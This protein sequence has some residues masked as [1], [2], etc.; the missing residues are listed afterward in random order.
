MEAKKTPSEQEDLAPSELKMEGRVS[1][2]DMNKEAEDHQDDRVSQVSQQLPFSSVLPYFSFKLTQ[3][4]L[5]LQFTYRF[6]LSKQ[7]LKFSKFSQKIIFIPI[8]GRPESVSLCLSFNFHRIAEGQKFGDLTQ[9][10]ST[11]VLK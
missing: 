1:S 5:C 2:K 9:I 10:W 8:W 4:N 6:L 7:P 11:G 3:N